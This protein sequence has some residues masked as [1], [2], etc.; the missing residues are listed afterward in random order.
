MEVFFS[1]D[2]KV[3]EFWNPESKKEDDE[4]MKIFSR[5]AAA[6]KMHHNFVGGLLEHVLNLIKGRIGKQCRERWHNHLNPAIKKT[7]WTMDE[8]WIIH[9]S[10]QKI[11]N[12]WDATENY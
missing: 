5:A 10:R 9:A 2:V 11:G 6:K 3:D 7:D 1:E 8:D 12:K 4:F